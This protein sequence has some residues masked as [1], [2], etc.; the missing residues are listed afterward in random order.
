[1]SINLYRI[2]ALGV[3]LTGPS[4]YLRFSDEI[5]GCFSPLLPFFFKKFQLSFIFPM[6]GDAL[7]GSLADKVIASGVDA[8]SS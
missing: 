5:D 1:M 7:K 3:M 6:V 8:C 4:I 2:R